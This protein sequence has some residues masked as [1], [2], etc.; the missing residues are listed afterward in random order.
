MV[1]LQEIDQASYEEWFHPQLN[2]ESEFFFLPIL[3]SSYNGLFFKKVSGKSLDG[4]AVFT[5]R[6]LTCTAS[7]C[8]RI[9]P[10]ENQVFAVVCLETL[11]GVYAL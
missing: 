7:L 1:C 11:H 5:R 3:I 8:D 6:T 2:A 9:L 10:D 4:L